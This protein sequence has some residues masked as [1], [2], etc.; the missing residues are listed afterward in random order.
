MDFTGMDA[1]SMMGSPEPRRT[2]EETKRAMIVT[3]AS[4][5]EEQRAAIELAAQKSG[6]TIS[7]FMRMAALSM[8]ARLGYHPQQPA[9]DADDFGAFNG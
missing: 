1:E 4:M 8:A 2:G 9:T 3:K 5:T 6:L 7:A